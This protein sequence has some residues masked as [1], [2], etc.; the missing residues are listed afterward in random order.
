MIDQIAFTIKF[1]K[2]CKSVFKK[3]IVCSISAAASENF[4]INCPSHA[5]RI[6]FLTENTAIEKQVINFMTDYKSIYI[7]HIFT[8]SMNNVS[9]Y[10][11][12]K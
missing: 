11:S 6:P 1:Y 4:N 12:F 10:I 7:D 2:S 9:S 3:I 5:E 8:S